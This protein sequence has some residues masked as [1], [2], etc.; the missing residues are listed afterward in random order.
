M[1]LCDELTVKIIMNTLTRPNYKSL[2]HRVVTYFTL[3][4]LEMLL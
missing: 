1:E 4:D 3:E 2:L